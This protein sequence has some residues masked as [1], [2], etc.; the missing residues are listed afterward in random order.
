MQGSRNRWHG[1]LGGEGGADFAD[2]GGLAAEVGGEGL[3]G[4]ECG[5]ADVVLHALDVVMDDLGVEAEEGEEIGEEL[6]AAG[7]VAGEGLA[8]GGEDEAAV[9]FVF[10][11]AL[12]V[13]ALDHVG[14][15]GL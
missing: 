9:F 2:E 8:G 1:M 10:E 11:E 7:D 14:D 13:E 3:D 15:A 6:V 5:G 4:A 12:C